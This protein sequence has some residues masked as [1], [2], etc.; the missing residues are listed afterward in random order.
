MIF[1]DLV[2]FYSKTLKRRNVRRLYALAFMF[3]LFCEVG[4]HALLDTHGHDE[5]PLSTTT[6]QADFNHPDHEC[7][8]AVACDED[9]RQD[10]HSPN[11]PDQSSHHD[12]LLTSYFYTFPLN[13]KEGERVISATSRHEF[14]ALSL[15]F[16][17][18]KHS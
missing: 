13:P 5:V 11:L 15:P 2:R 10:P 7:D 1:G 17:P 6:T 18:P 9:S 14:K 8:C 3:F 12:V 16:L 4:S